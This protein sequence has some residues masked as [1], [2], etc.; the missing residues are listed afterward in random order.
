[1]EGH[2]KRLSDSSQQPQFARMKCLSLLL[3][4]LL[5]LS[6]RGFHAPGYLQL[7]RRSIWIDVERSCEALALVR[8]ASRRGGK[9][10]LVAA[11]SSLR[12][13][14]G[15]D[16]GLFEI[17][18]NKEQEITQFKS[19]HS[20]PQD[21]LRMLLGYMD[22]KPD[23]TSNTKLV[24][25][26]R[27]QRAVARADS[28]SS[29]LQSLDV[30]PR[31]TNRALSIGV[32][33][34]RSSPTN[35][36]LRCNFDDAGAVA[37]SFVSDGADFV[38]VNADFSSYGGDIDDVKAVVSSLSEKDVPVIF[39]DFIIDPLQLALAKDLGCDAVIVMAC[40]VGPELGELLDTATVMNLPCIVEVHTIDE[41]NV[42]LEAGAQILLVNRFDRLGGNTFFKEQPNAIRELLPPG[43][44]ITTI[45][46]GAI[47][48]DEDC[49][50]LLD[51]GYDAVLCG[52]GLMGN[53]NSRQF[54]QTVKYLD[55]SNNA[56]GWQV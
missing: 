12:S 43:G 38:V 10:D 9:T 32:D 8:G 53:P 29:D 30:D 11:T 25:A 7:P 46:T 18:R 36:N 39:K 40:V 27:R 54:M 15:N 14:S 56:A 16:Y 44:F 6:A 33:L 41:V 28:A 35:R 3:N 24:R 23:I 2:Q 49:Q 42:A 37:S 47:S 5:F 4:A 21:P 55:L 52:R 34:K 31:M 17:I 20:N 1:M 50:Q 51:N 48:E 19:E 45:A 26:L 13:T 22:E